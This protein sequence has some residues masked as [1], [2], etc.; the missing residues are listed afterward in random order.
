MVLYININVLLYGMF[1]ISFLFNVFWVI[2]Y[3]LMVNIE[4]GIIKKCFVMILFF[5]FLENV[6]D[7]VE[8]IFL[9]KN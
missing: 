7:I 1:Y 8:N 5:I 3:W 6:K 2:I 9:K 4:C